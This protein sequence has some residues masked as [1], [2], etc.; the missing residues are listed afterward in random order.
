M[1]HFTANQQVAGPTY[2]D[3]DF[4]TNYT[5]EREWEGICRREGW[6]NQYQELTPK[7]FSLGWDAAGTV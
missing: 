5:N 6:N 4:D 1:G 7:W 3:T 2:E